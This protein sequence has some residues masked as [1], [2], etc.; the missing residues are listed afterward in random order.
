MLY[1]ASAIA[2]DTLEAGLGARGVSIRRIDTYTTV[3]ATWSDTDEE[4]A[5]AAEIVTFAS[6]SAV[7]VWADR[8]GTAAAAV[9]WPRG[10]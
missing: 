4:R 8:M 5:R 3:P 2:S 1:P 7:R 10:S 6:P 9:R